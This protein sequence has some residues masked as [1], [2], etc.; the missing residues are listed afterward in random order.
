MT[1][2]R[3]IALSLVL[4]CGL[5][6][7]TALWADGPRT[8]S[9]P[10]DAAAA[11]LG[12]L[13]ANDDKAL[14]AIFGPASADV[15]QEGSDPVVAASR[16]DIAA[17]GK[18]KLAVEGADT[19]TAILEF[20]EEG[21]PSPIPVV[22]EGDKWRF[23]VAAGREEL[24]ARR[25][26]ANELRA[27]EIAGDYLDMQADYASSDRD[28]DGVREFAQKL[29]STPGQQDGLYWDDPTGTDPSPLA[30]ELDDA[31]KP[32]A[33]TSYGGYRWKILTAQGP[34]APGGQYSYVINGNMVAGFALVG[35]PADYRETGVT[36]FVI[37]NN[38][39]L[40]QK[41]LGAK[42]TESVQAMTAFD[43]DGTWI[44]IVDEDED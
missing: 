26:G 6:R 28:G 15:V 25:I 4:A 38:G 14:L 32:A 42:T 35:A 34:N 44:E 40:Y 8:F 12:A 17:Q 22:R 9:S 2:M 11:L 30:L 3:R 24:L 33:G 21:W 43:P 20:G 18:K 13:E 27:I 10:E 37:S 41:D 31:V 23:D 1:R 36:T 29:T 7:P 39:K 19:G 16:K 5:G